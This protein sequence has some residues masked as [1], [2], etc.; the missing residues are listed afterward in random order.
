VAGR[1]GAILRRTDAI[2]TVSIPKLPTG[3]RRDKPK[4]GAEGLP[5]S[6][7]IQRALP[8]PNK[9]KPPQG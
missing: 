3:S 1:G 8:P 4:L 2:N 7:D 6:G 9:K 5:A